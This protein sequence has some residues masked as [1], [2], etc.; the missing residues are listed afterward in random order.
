MDKEKCLAGREMMKDYAREQ[1]DWTQTDQAMGVEVPPTEVR[2]PKGLTRY[3]LDPPSE[4]GDAFTLSDIRQV[5]EQRRSRRKYTGEK[6]TFNQLSGLLWATAGYRHPPKK[7]MRHA[8]SAG[9]R[10]P[11]ETYAIVMD[12]DEIP[13][14]VYRYVPSQHALDLISDNADGLRE[15]AIAATRGQVWAGTAGVTF[16]FAAVPY[17]TE[18]RYDYTAHRVILMDVGHMCQN[19]YLAATAMGLGACAMAAY[20]QDLVDHLIGV[21]GTDQFAVYLCSVGVVA[22]EE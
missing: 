13:P 15:R 14:G 12:S 11:I 16:V 4:I 3:F 2:M 6:L 21:D 8:P 19:L 1:V 9:N 18:W 7:K 22:E 20:T 5:I 17:R 10:Q